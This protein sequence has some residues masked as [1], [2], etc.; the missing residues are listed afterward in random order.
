MRCGRIKEGKQ[1]TEGKENCTVR[2]SKAVT[3]ILEKGESEARRHSN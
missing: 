2:G 3:E 1:V